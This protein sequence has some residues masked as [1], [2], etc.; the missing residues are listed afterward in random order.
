MRRLSALPGLSFLNS[1]LV[2][3]D[4]VT[5]RIDDV[6]GDYVERAGAVRQ[7]AG[8]VGGAVLGDDAQEDADGEASYG[9]ADQD[10]EDDW[11]Y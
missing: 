7:V 8:E 2:E 3:A 5:G 4:I 6:V 11:E 9:P 1:W 10:V